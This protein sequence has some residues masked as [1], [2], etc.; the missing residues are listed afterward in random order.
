MFATTRRPEPERRQLNYGRVLVVSSNVRYV[1][2]VS[3][4][5]LGAKQGLT[6][7]QM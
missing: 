1:A 3:E 4:A 7:G 5:Q 6:R 2:E